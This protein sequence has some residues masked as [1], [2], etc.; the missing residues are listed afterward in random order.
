MCSYVNDW[1]LYNK[2][3]FYGKLLFEKV[4]IIIINILLYIKVKIPDD[5]KDSVLSKMIL[6]IIKVI[7]IT[8]IENYCL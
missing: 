2:T 5:F 6:K 1:S 4:V 7:F 8:M 3:C